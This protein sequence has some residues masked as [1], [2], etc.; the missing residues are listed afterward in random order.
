MTTTTTVIRIYSSPTGHLDEN[1]Q[2]FNPIGFYEQPNLFFR[3][4]RDGTFDE[5][6]T[7]SGSGMHLEK[8]SRGFAYSD[9]DND[10][11]LDLFVTNLKGTPDLLQNRGKSKYVADPQTHWHAQQPGRDSGQESR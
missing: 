11:D 4:N 1:V 9:Y 7:D 3:N 2:A 6:G 10:G 5:V 8:V